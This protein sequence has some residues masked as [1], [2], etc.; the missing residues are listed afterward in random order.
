[1]RGGGRAAA[2]WPLRPGLAAAVFCLVATAAGVITAA[3][4]VV[5]ED[6]LI[7]QADR[8]LRGYAG[9]LTSRPFTLFPGWRLAPGA[10]GLGATGRELSIEVRAPG[11]QLLISAGPAAPPADGHGW[12]ELSEPVRYQEEHIPFVYGADDSSF[13]VTGK[14]R[15]GFAGTL[16]VALDVAGVGQ[17]VGSLTACCLAVSALVLLLFSCAAAAVARALL[18]PAA[19]AASAEAAAARD[20]TERAAAVLAATCRE[21]RR[22][23]SL[24]T[25]L[26]G[27]CLER[28]DRNA[29]DADRVLGQVA[30]AS[31]AISVLVEELG[32]AARPSGQG[33]GCRPLAQPESAGPAGSA[34][35]DPRSGQVPTVS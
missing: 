21:M 13:S 27:F 29:R 14:A 32:A 22:P 9:L 30:D 6:F 3:G 11:G 20:Y 2:R 25:G 26:A 15:P 17:A 1:L 35:A 19:L 10:S 7:R 33:S 4:H 34:S 28:D 31:A 18:R 24:L 5:A 8:Q 12:L 23:L 16:V